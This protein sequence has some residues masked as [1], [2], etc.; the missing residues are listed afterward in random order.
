VSGIP[1]INATVLFFVLTNGNFGQISPNVLQFGG[2][3]LI[4]IGLQVVV[5]LDPRLDL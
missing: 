3:A 2:H 5:R 4:L 1:F